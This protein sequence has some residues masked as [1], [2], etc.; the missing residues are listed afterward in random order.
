MKNRPVITIDGVAASG[1][2]S[3]AKALAQKLGFSYLNSG[4]LY[5]AVGVIA[6]RNNVGFEDE[7]K[8]AKL[9]HPGDLSLNEGLNG[10]C[11]VW[12]KNKVISDS[13][14]DTVEV[15]TAASKVATIQS[16]R[17]LLLPIQQC[18]FPEKGLVAEGR[19]MG[20]VVFPEAKIKIFISA[21]PLVRAQRRAMQL[22]TPLKVHEI[23]SEIKERDLRDQTRNI[24]PMIIP[25]GAIEFSNSE[26]DF[27]S[28]VEKLY[29]IVISRL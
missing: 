8:L 24:S 19:D 1:K 3:L 4:N 7:S 21:T 12:Y 22:N 20:S 14:L 2:S 6:L 11:E 17:N 10:K 16:I 9:I 5:R 27:D 29:Q 28:Q 13:E 26:G 23:E 15:A 25:E 18:A